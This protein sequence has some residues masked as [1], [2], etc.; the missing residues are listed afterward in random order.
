MRDDT[1]NSCVA[2]YPFYTHLSLNQNMFVYTVQ[3]TQYSICSLNYTST[4]LWNSL[5][6]HVKENCPF[7]R[8]CQNIENPIIEGYN[9]VIE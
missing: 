4:K 5:T 8:C 7:S 3:T 9:S 2:D 1:K 6:S